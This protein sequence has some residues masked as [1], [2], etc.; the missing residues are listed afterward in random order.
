MKQYES[1]IKVMENNGG[2][3]TL[4][5]L[6]RHVDVSNWK[7]K[8]PFASIRRIVQDEKYFFKIRPGL[9]ALKEFE[10]QVLSKFELTAKNKTDSDDKFNHSYYQGLLVEIGNLKGYVTYV[11]PQDKNKRFLD[12]P[13]GSISRVETIFDFTY[14]SIVNRAKTVDVIW[15][16]D[17]KLPYS[18]FEI[19]HSTNIQN[20]LLKFND[21]QDFYSQ[22]YIVSDSRR[23]KEF[24]MKIHYDAF[25]EIKERIRFIDYDFVSNLH[26][27]SFELAS[28]GD[29]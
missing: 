7:T 6:N 19:E 23:K 1:V 15:F 26:T 11:P 21:L 17:R 9:W 3:A 16:N 27:K 28:I 18:F 25:K 12:K 22:F 13:L 4:G 2:Y 5:F 10:K 29:L 8:T 14:D 24:N 20:S